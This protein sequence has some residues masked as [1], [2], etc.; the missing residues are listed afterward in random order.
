MVEGAEKLGALDRVGEEVGLSADGAGSLS[1]W[2]EGVFHGESL[3][4]AG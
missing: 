3:N 4:Q 2:A 1:G